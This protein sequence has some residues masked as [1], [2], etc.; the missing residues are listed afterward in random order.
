[1][2]V[3]GCN[4]G[5]HPDN[6]HARLSAAGPVTASTSEVS[7]IKE[8]T[9]MTSYRRNFMTCALAIFIGVSAGCGRESQQDTREPTDTREHTEFEQVGYFKSAGLRGFTFFVTDPNKQDI[10]AFCQKQKLA[11]PSGTVLKIHFFDDRANT[12]DVT[13]K[14]YFPESSNAYLVADYFFNPF[15]GKQGLK[16]HK[17]ISAQPK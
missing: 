7:A 12:P 11:F 9:M 6:T 8:N 1:M 4:R 10:E 17:D 3:G 13:L 15:N 2:P 16:V 5:H 14:Y